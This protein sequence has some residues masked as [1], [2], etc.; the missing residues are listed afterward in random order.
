MKKEVKLLASDGDGL[1]ND[2]TL[3][4]DEV[5]IEESNMYLADD[6]ITL[7]AGDKLGVKN[8]TEA[9]P[10]IF[11]ATNGVVILKSGGE[12]KIEGPF[13][14]FVPDPIDDP[15]TTNCVLAIP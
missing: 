2:I 15:S 14:S 5:D 3:S 8:G 4:A 12:C 11:S 9:K 13:I 7:D 1:L 10:A 6:V